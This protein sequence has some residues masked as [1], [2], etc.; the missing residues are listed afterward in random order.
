KTG[1][2]YDADGAWG[3]TGTANT[4]L[5]EYLLGSEPWF[6]LPPPKSTGRDLFNLRWLQQRLDH[7]E[8]TKKG[9]ADADIQATLVLLTAH[10]AAQAIKAHAPDTADVLVCGGGACNPRVVSALETVLNLPV[11]PTSDAGVP[12]QVVEALAFAWLAWAHEAG[13]YAGLPT[14]T[15]ARHPSL[16]G[17]RYPGTP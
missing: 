11:T 5:L 13:V 15:G 3:A 8:A 7:F 1:Q 14:V 17:C 9:L 16:L 4:D 2:A 6:T 12:V 10:S